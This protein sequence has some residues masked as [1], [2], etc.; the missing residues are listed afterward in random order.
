MKIIAVLLIITAANLFAQNSSLYIPI[1]VKQAYDSGTRSYDGAPGENYWINKAAYKMNVKLDPE[2]KHIYA[3]A[4]IKYYNESPDSLNEIVF[5]LYQQLFKKGNPRDFGLTPTDIHD[6]TNL[7]VIKHGNDTLLLGS[8]RIKRS[9][10][11]LSILLPDKMAPG[12]EE[13]FYFDWDVKL[14][15]TAT[16]R[17][18][19]YSDTSFFVAYWYP[20]IAVYHDIDGWDRNEYTGYTETYNDGE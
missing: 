14:P 8:K 17:M 12:S 15:E 11:T 5:K 6:G 16:V 19:A 13:T 9:S 4:E 10:T 3:T 7:N 1:N 20:Q 18:G 2:K